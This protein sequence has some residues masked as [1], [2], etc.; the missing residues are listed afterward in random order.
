MSKNGWMKSTYHEIEDG[1]Q[2]QNRKWSRQY[3]YNSEPRWNLE[4]ALKGRRSHSRERLARRQRQVAMQRELQKI[5]LSIA[6]ICKYRVAM[7]LRINKRNTVVCVQNGKNREATQWGHVTYWTA[8]ESA[9]QCLCVS[10]RL[11][12]IYI[13]LRRST[14]SHRRAVALSQHLTLPAVMPCNY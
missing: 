9:R 2:R 1:R 7:W 12:F 14:G 10:E 6:V 11:D 3:Q 5:L 8:I 13:R 4:N